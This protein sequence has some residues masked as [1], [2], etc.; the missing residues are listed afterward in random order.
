MELFGLSDGDELEVRL[1]DGNIVL[2]PLCDPFKVLEEV[3]G[4]FTYDR[5]AGIEAE[6][7]LYRVAGQCRD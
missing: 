3:L 5:E 2:E 6:K 7:Y 4:D 1:E